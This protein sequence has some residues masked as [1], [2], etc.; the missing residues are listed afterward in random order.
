MTFE[1]QLEPC[2]MA[3]FF[4]FCSVISSIL[5]GVSV[6]Y[7]LQGTPTHLLWGL[8]AAIFAASLHC[9]V[10]AIFTGSGKDT[11]LL[12]ED[13]SLNQEYV[14]RTKAFKK[15]VFPPALYAIF[16]LLILTTLGGAT[17]KAGISWVG[18]LHG[19]WAV[20][21][22]FYNLK[23]YWKEYKAIKLNS[24]ILKDLNAKAGEILS[25]QKPEITEFTV[26]ESSEKV[27]DL[28]WGTHVYAFGRF[29][30]FLSWNTWL[31]YLYFRFIM[32]ELR[33]PIWPFILVSAILGFGG[34]LL[35]YKYQNFKP[36]FH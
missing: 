24:E 32:G 25:H 18:W 13:L 3:K 9:L 22:I 30:G 2:I 16:F 34:W 5:F 21:T 6:F 31:V 28:E 4:G 35:K 29:L 26:G 11:R 12:V 7:G 8:G 19:L 36:K 14:K 23:T 20:F 27:A 17:S 33:T 10:F 1:F 15:E